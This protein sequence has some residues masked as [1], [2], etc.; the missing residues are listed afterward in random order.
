MINTSFGLHL[1]IVVI[2]HEDVSE[3]DVRAPWTPP[4]SIR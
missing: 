2:R 4:E 1:S 3:I